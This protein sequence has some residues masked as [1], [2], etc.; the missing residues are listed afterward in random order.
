MPLKEI[1][2]QLSNTRFEQYFLALGLLLQAGSAYVY[3]EYPLRFQNDSNV[4]GFVIFTFLLGYFLLVLGISGCAWTYK[5][6][7]GLDD[8]LYKIKRLKAQDKLEKLVESLGYE[9]VWENPEKRLMRK[10]R[11]YKQKKLIKN[12]NNAKK[13]EKYRNL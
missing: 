6:R 2:S 9:F 5:K 1:S 13:E 11:E 12:W 10:W 7:R 8:V 4:H 3:L